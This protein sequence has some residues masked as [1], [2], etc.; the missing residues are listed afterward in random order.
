MFLQESWQL[1]APILP[2]LTLI[3]LLVLIIILLVNPALYYACTSH[4]PYETI[5]PDRTKA[6]WCLL[7]PLVPHPHASLKYIVANLAANTVLHGLAWAAMLGTSPV[8]WRL[9]WRPLASVWPA[10]L[11]LAVLSGL[12]V[13]PYW[14]LAL[15]PLR[16]GVARHQRHAFDGETNNGLVAGD[17][18]AKSVYVVSTS[19]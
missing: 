14:F 19:L 11:I 8:V 7:S 2:S 3:P 10:L 13:V 17:S 4:Q 18:A 15:K 9:A 16:K 1:I 6:M 5:V 12:S